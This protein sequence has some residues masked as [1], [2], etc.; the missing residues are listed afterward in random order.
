MLAGTPAEVRAG[1]IGGPVVSLRSTTGPRLG[2]LWNLGRIA[3]PARHDAD[4]LEPVSVLEG[5]V[6]E[7]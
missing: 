6:R 2:C 1:G 3:S 5:P 7:L 4:D